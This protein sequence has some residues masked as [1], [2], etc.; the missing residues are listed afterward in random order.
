MKKKNRKKIIILVNIY[1]LG[2]YSK[3]PWVEKFNI[4]SVIFR[5]CSFW[6]KKTSET[7]KESILMKIPIIDNLLSN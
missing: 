5:K 4:L 6:L 1:F 7:A 3:S 2:I